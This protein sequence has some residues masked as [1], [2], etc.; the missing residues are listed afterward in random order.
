MAGTHKYMATAAVVVALIGAP[1]AAYAVSA[2]TSAHVSAQSAARKAPTPRIVASGEHVTEPGGADFWLTTEGKHWTTL[3][4]PYPQFT[5]VV[6]GNIDLGS[7]GVSAHVETSADGHVLLSGVY[8]GGKGTASRV[9][10]RTTA[11]TLHG[12]LLELA[13][14][15]GWG[16]WYV[17]TD[18]PAGND[19]LSVENVVV[20]D[21]HGKVYSRLDLN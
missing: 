7:P 18:V 5:S 17:S 2:G 12:K 9:T 4:N 14:E 11:G 16:A 3:D 19:G 15:P 20:R 6:D 13:G 10:V 1:S 21:T 8:Y